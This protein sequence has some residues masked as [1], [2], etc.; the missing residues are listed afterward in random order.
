MSSPIEVT[1]LICRTEGASPS[2]LRGALPLA[3]PVALAPPVRLEGGWALGVAHAAVHCALHAAWRGQREGAAGRRRP[4]MALALRPRG[5]RRDMRRTRIFPWPCAC[6]PP[7][8]GGAGS[9]A[10]SGERREEGALAQEM[11]KS[12]R[13]FSS[14]HSSF[15]T[16]DDVFPD[17]RDSTDLPSRESGLLQPDEQRVAARLVDRLESVRPDLA[18]NVPRD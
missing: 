13:P 17:R 15:G 11:T 1:Q 2:V 7:C 5:R 3:L 16:L 4:R 10:S 8:L 6:R 18:Q 12:T 14:Y 9:I